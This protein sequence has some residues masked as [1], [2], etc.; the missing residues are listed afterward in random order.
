MLESS[1]TPVSPISTQGPGPRE[2]VASFLRLTVDTPDLQKAKMHLTRRSAESGTFDAAAVPAGSSYT[3]GAEEADELGR[4]IPVSVKSP[5][6]GTTDMQEMT[7]PVIVVQ[8]EGEWKIDLPA[9]MERLMGGMT[10][11]LGSAMEAVGEALSTAMSGV[12][13]ALAAGMGGA[14]QMVKAVAAK[15]KAKKG[16]SGRAKKPAASARKKAPKKPAAKAARP[17][18]KSARKAA[19]APA[20]KSAAKSAAKSVKSA[21]KVKSRPGKKRR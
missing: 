7:V 12:G 5:V 2:V 8:E 15:V 14:E 3:L 6:P 21:R 16:A 19:K 11:A 1:A 13:E 17:A 10:S 18:K 9:T 4:R 20:R